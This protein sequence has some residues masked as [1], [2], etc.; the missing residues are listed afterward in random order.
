MN[1]NNL[2][3]S[4]DGGGSKTDFLIADIKKKIKKE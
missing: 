1:Q 4:I 3:I 2:I